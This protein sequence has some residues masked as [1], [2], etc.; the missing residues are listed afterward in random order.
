[1]IATNPQIPPLNL[2]TGY[3]FSYFLRWAL[4]SLCCSF[5]LSVSSSYTSVN[6]SSMPGSYSN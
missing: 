6:M 5:K 4:I 2:C 1:M 3:S